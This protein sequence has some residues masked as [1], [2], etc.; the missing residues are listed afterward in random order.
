ML[1][2]VNTV[3]DVSKSC[4]YVSYFFQ[5]LQEIDDD[6]LKVV[7]GSS[8]RNPASVEAE[9]RE[10]EKELKLPGRLSQDQ[11]E[12]DKDFW[13][14][15]PRT[16]SYQSSRFEL[17]LDISVL[18]KMVP[19]DYLSR[20]VS[21][22]SSRRQLYNKV[23][24][25]HRSLK[26]G[27]LNDTTMLL[28]LEEVLG[29]NLTEVQKKK[30]WDQLGIT[31]KDQIYCVFAYEQFCGIAAMTERLF[32]HEFA[33]S[34]SE[35]SNL[36]AKSEIE[37]ADFDRLLSKIQDVQMNSK[38]RDLLMKI[39]DSGVTKS[40]LLAASGGHILTRKRSTFSFI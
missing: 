6:L 28:A 12:E 26:D 4:L 18:S 35:A 40:S 24:V 5:R 32:C 25:R 9:I 39:K 13:L 29:S 23:F 1:F 31:P 15:L 21:V 20:Y 11:S 14:S 22:S 30:I 34:K 38:L 37:V 10:L 19:L 7:R 2:K 17:P 3:F 27:L 16:F 33:T 36:E 8:G